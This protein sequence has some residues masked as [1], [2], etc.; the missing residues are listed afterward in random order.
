MATRVGSALQRGQ[1]RS[2]SEH[3]V[4][5]SAVAAGPAL[6]TSEAA[7]QAWPTI[8]VMGR[9]DG[10]GHGLVAAVRQRRTA[11]IV[12]ALTAWLITGASHADPPSRDVSPS[13]TP[14][15]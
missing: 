3:V 10:L 15:D 9:G 5:V 7:T 14:R 11:L 1:L 4:G 12:R 2:P 8:P 13:A 6:A